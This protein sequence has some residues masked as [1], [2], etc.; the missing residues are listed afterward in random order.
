MNYQTVFYSPASGEII[1]VLPNR[2]IHSKADKLSCCH[3]YKAEDVNF[4]YFK[5]SIPVD[6][7]AHR[8]VMQEN[9]N[10]P[11][12]V[13][14]DGVPLIFFGVQEP[15]LDAIKNFSNIIIDFEDGMGDQFYRANAVLEAQKKYP[16]IKFYCKVD[17]SFLPVVSLIPGINILSDALNHGLDLKKCATVK[18]SA[19]LL[20]DPLG[21]F[22]DAPS[23][24]GLFLGLLKIPYDIRLS[25][26]YDFGSDLTELKE[27]IGLR[28]DGHNIFFQLITSTDV[29]RSWSPS[30]ILELA[31]LIK[32][33]YD[34]NIYCIGQARDIV[35]AG[36]DIINL[37][38]QTSWLDTIFLLLNASHVFCVDSSVNHLCHAL[39]IQPYV[40]YGFTQP[41]GVI[42]SRPSKFD[43]GARSSNR[44]N[45]VG[46][47]TP[48][49]VFNAAFPAE[50]VT[51][52]VAGSTIEDTSQHGEK[53]IIYNFFKDNIP[54]YKIVVDVGAYGKDM[55]N[56]WPLLADGWSGLLIEAN[57]DR[58][59]IIKKEFTGLNY[60][61]F[62]NGVGPVAGT[63][64]FYL[65]SVPGH[66]SFLK[67]WYPQTLTNKIK[68]VAV[69]TLSSFLIDNDIPLDFDFLTIDTEG[70]DRAIMEDL[71]LNS[72][73]RPSLI[74]TECTSYIDDMQIFID[75]GYKLLAF[76][77][78]K[79]FGNYIFSKV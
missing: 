24:Y 8:I 54:K 66:N 42:G 20:A 2:Y 31:H 37:C 71:F 67:D 78:E 1:K 52:D 34:C 60:K 11:I 43:L 13:K 33:V 26:P 9:L 29:S 74:V 5:A 69:K 75:A 76:T 40:L 65:H 27:K 61:L 73:F 39:G 41:Q 62:N 47:V 59:K 30:Y 12:V 50:H 6:P 70:L 18:M 10:A 55:S 49:D 64:P 57:P 48:I 63:L 35:D 32:S 79:D 51:F 45:V 15:F 3:G 68:N 72:S 44:K 56:S 46:S 25:I 4:T 58:C 17:S 21:D 7:A 53:E 38:G 22:F 77:G 14:E 28:P 23:R 36:P 19:K 16:D